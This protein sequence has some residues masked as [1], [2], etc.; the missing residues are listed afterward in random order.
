MK[1]LALLLLFVSTASA[2]SGVT[3]AF[4]AQTYAKAS[5]DVDTSASLS[6]GFANYVS[7]Q[8]QSTGSDSTKLYIAVDGLTRLGNWSLAMTRDTLTLGRPA[9]WV[10]DSTHGQW[11]N[12]A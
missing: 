2:Q 3:T 7:L 1:F 8:T 5:T 12:V 11:H 9:P 10:L 4:S 6:V